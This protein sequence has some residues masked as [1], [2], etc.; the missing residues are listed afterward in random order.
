MINR[1]RE[2]I[3]AHYVE[4]YAT[5]KLVDIEE[6]FDLVFSRSLGLVFAKLGMKW[7]WSPTQVSVASLV[8][9]TVGG[10]LLYYQNDWVLTVAGSL[11]VTFAGVLDSAD[12]QLARMTKT[13]SELGRM[14]DGLIDNWVFLFCYLFATLYFVPIYGWWIF[15]FGVLAGV[16]QSTKSTIYDF[17]KSEYMYFG[18]GFESA[19]I[20]KLEGNAT[21]EWNKSILGKVLF[22]MNK[23]YTQNQF[24]T[25]TRTSEL[26]AIY[27]KYAFS[28][29]TQEKFQQMYKEQFKGMM[30]WWALVCGSNFHRTLIMFFS[31]I[32]RFD[33]YIG[34]NIV[35]YLPMYIIN[36]AQK[37]KDDAFLKRLELEFNGNSK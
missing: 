21:G 2:R 32:G 17:Y 20:E 16:A 14:I 25:T 36:Y 9:G 26:R 24:K 18:G 5:I 30:F 33:I 19:K 23:Q 22:S 15:V 6:R 31:I 4:V 34:I 29:D 3:K 1:I 7:N 11:L 12:G 37:L 27:E 10:V 28:T 13:S 35:T 8:F